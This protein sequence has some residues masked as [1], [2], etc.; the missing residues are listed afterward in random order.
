MAEVEDM[1]A[2]LFGLGVPVTLRPCGGADYLVVGRVLCPGHHGRRSIA[3]T[4]LGNSPN[5]TRPIYLQERWAFWGNFQGLL[6]S[7]IAA[8]VT[9]VR[10]IVDL[11]CIHR[12]PIH[13]PMDMAFLPSAG[14]HSYSPH[15]HSYLLPYPRCPPSWHLVSS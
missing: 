14:K 3:D 7:S 15:S 2:V 11:H 10:L 1:V 4:W 9:R 5:P 12:L 8:F 13:N 6:T